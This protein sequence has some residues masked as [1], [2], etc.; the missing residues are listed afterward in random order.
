VPVKRQTRF[1]PE[2]IPRAEPARKQPV[3]L[4]R[5]KEHLPERARVLRRAINFIPV[6]S[7]V[8]GAGDEALNSPEAK[9][10]YEGV[11]F[12]RQK[13]GPEKIGQKRRR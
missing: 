1:Q 13:A 12:F 6:L 11:V 5:G 3:P 8:P 2:R 7:R 9:S 4:S 10:P